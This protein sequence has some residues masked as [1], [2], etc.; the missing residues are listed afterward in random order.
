MFKDEQ[1]IQNEDF[2]NYFFLLCHSNY[3]NFTIINKILYSVNK[4][5]VII[6]LFCS[7]H[8]DIQSIKL[9]TLRM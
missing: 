9:M 4:Y 3:F 2:S 5:I 1:N 7:I 6:Y 8:S